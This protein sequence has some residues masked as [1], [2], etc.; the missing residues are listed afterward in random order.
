MHYGHVPSPADEK[1]E[2]TFGSVAGTYHRKEP[3]ELRMAK[4]PPRFPS[5]RPQSQDAD[6]SEYL[7]LLALVA[8]IVGVVFLHVAHVRFP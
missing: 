2:L 1:L 3:K 4:S 5:N 7:L 6:V 8:L